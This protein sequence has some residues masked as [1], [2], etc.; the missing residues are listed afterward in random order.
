MLFRSSI[1]TLGDIAPL[2]TALLAPEPH[3]RQAAAEE[4]GTL[5]NPKAIDALLGTLGDATA[6]VRNAARQ[7]LTRLGWIP[8]GAKSS[9][10]AAGYDRWVLRS[11][12]QPAAIETPQIDVLL[13][14]V[15]LADP[16]LRAAVAEALA[17]FDDPRVRGALAT[18]AQDTDPRVR[19]AARPTGSAG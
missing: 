2:I 18:L 12:F 14:A 4:L 1:S 11:E 15:G 13:G 6:A 3:V 5:G 8:I 7:A 10:E 19:A 16:V 9:A 17:G